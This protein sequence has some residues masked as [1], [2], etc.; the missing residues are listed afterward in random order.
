M[1][2]AVEHLPRK[3]KILSSNPHTTKEIN[4]KLKPPKKIGGVAEVVG[5]SP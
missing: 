5:C 4:K 1:A 2:Q 3:C